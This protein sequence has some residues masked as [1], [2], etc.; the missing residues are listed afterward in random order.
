LVFAIEF[1]PRR[2]LV[3]IAADIG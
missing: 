2:V 1:P 3:D